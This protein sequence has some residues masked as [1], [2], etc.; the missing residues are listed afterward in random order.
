M[1]KFPFKFFA[2]LQLDDF[3]LLLS[4]KFSLYILDIGLIKFINWKSLSPL[5]RISFPSEHN[6]LLFCESCFI[7]ALKRTTTFGLLALRPGNQDLVMK[8][9]VCVFSMRLRVC[10]LLS[11]FLPFSNLVSSTH[12]GVESQWTLLDHSL[13]QTVFS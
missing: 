9:C 10:L 1:E 2:Q 5:Y 11:D 3:F 7:S 8:M 12:H 6:G 4:F 13:N